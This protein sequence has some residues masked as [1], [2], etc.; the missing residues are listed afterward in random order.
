MLF[1]FA[2]QVAQLRVFKLLKSVKEVTVVVVCV[3]VTKL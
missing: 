2:V 3:F 1:F